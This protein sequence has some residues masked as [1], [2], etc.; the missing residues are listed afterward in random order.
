MTYWGTGRAGVMVL[1]LAY[2]SGSAHG[3]RPFLQRE[4]RRCFLDPHQRCAA[5]GDAE[6]IL[7]EAVMVQAY[8][9]KK[10]TVAG[11]HVHDF[12][13]DPQDYYRMDKVWL[14]C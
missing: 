12:R 1:E 14:T 10:F 9:P 7:E 6:R 13:A 4:V 11:A 8:F 3:T 5:M 2:R